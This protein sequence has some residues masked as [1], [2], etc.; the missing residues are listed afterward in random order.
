MQQKPF[1]ALINKNLAKHILMRKS[2]WK[3][4]D[5]INHLQLTDQHCLFSFRNKYKHLYSFIHLRFLRKANL[6]FQIGPPPLYSL[7]WV[8]KEPKG[9]ASKELKS[10]HHKNQ[11]AKKLGHIVLSKK[12]LA[13]CDQVLDKAANASE[14]AQTPPSFQ[15]GGCWDY[16]V[17]W[18]LKTPRTNSSF[19]TAWETQR[20]RRQTQLCQ[21]LSGTGQL[22]FLPLAASHPPLL[23]PSLPPSLPTTTLH[24]LTGHMLTQLVNVTVNVADQTEAAGLHTE[25]WLQL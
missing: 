20:A 11:R 14:G 9:N 15:P 24:M 18:R 2:L 25:L 21:V 3:N 16:S 22:L 1:W 7:P 17:S 13:A 12:G 19:L 8:T 6:A 23:S 10:Q 5:T 4:N